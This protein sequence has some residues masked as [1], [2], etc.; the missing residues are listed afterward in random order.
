MVAKIAQYDEAS[1]WGDGQWSQE[2][3]I[4]QSRSSTE[5]A[6]GCIDEEEV[7]G[8]KEVV[9]RG[10]GV[11]MFT[12]SGGADTE[13]DG[14]FLKTGTSRL[15]ERGRALTEGQR[16]RRIQVTRKGFML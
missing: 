15:P 4:D 13:K 16:A 10:R 3:N 14:S 2:S 8:G 7:V 9:F 11:V 5:S 12:A 1:C 6:K